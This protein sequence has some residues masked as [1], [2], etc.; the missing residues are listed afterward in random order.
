MAQLLFEWDSS[1]NTSNIK[2][3]GISFE[4]AKT[5]FTD[6]YARMIG[7]P[8]HSEDEDRFILLGTSIDSRLLVVCHCI[9]EQES[10]RIISARK[11]D[12]QERNIYERYRHA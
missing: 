7:D 2:K 6:E 4:E 9:R 12:K 1:K 10:I 11:A 8:D 3:H 5:V